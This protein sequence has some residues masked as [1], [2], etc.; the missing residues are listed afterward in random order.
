MNYFKINSLVVINRRLTCHLFYMPYIPGLHKFLRHE[1][2]TNG[3]ILKSQALASIHAWVR[4]V[5][6]HMLTNW[7]CLRPVVGTRNAVGTFSY[8]L[9]TRVF[10]KPGCPWTHFVLQDDFGPVASTSQMTGLQAC[11]TMPGHTFGLG[12]TPPKKKKTPGEI[13][14]SL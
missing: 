9:K 5:G 4:W 8:F 14:V 1:V 7:P 13:S 6:Q 2:V 3:R 12:S 10:C 11:A